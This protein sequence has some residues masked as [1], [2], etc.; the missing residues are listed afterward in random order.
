MIVLRS[1][2][3]NT[4]FYIVTMGILLVATPFYFFLPRR[5]CMAIVTFWGVAVLWLLKAICGVTH[6][7][8]GLEHIPADGRFIFA[9]KHQSTWETF[10]L[11]PT[12]RDPAYVIKS[13]LL[14]VPVWGW[15]ALKARMIFV[16]RSAGTAALRKVANGAKRE[17][18]RGRPVFIFPEGTRRAPG[19]PPDYKLGI[20]FLYRQLKVPVLPAG[21]NSGLYWPRRQFLRHPGRIVVEFLPPIAPG[22]GADAFKA[23]LEEAIEGSSD[24]LLKEAASA[25]HPPPLPESAVTR[26]RQ[27][28]GRP[29]VPA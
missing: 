28:E 25:P 3:F 26:L 17:L 11:L 1:L 24:R 21:L 6:E 19:A 4:A 18:A 16:D 12:F 10:A 15:W 14:W 29:A 22:L 20:V 27:M 23:R 7:L 9:G 13:Q 5:W 2:A 8:R